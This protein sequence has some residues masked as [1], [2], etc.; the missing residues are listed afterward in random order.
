MVERSIVLPP[1]IEY[2][3]VFSNLMQPFMLKLRLAFFIGLGLVFPFLVLQAWGFVAPGL[4]PGEKKPI[5]MM[6][7]FSVVLFAVGCVF[8]WLILP[9]AYRFF[10]GYIADFPGTHLYQDP[11]A[12]VFF[13]VKMLIAFGLGF[14]LP[15]LVFVLGKAGILTPETMMEHWRQAVVFIFIL[16]AVLT[17]TGDVL[18]LSMMAVPLT[19][20]FVVSVYAVKATTKK[21][22][23]EVEAV[24]YESLE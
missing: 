12:M 22:K 11:A 13:T 18:S 7:P 19:L 15:L 24:P 20:L 5:R 4:K 17:P 2:Q 3:P 16:S 1:G 14:Q 9:N 10:T 21:S 23:D 8:C 6:A